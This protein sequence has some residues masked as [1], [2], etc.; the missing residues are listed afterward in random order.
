MSAAQQFDLFSANP[1]PAELRSRGAVS[2]PAIDP[3]ALS[4]D[5]LVLALAGAP[6]R[7]CVG[8]VAEVGRRRL[9]GAISALDALCRRFAG[10]GVNRV[11]PEQAAALDALAAIGGPKAREALARLIA[12]GVVQGPGLRTALAA[13]ARVNVKIPATT[14]LRLLRNDDPQIR[15]AA[16]RCARS[17]PE[18]VSLLRD[19]LDDLHDEVRTAAACALG[20]IGQSEVRPLLAGLLRQA[21]S[22]ELI[23]AIAGVADEE[24]ITLLG[25]IALFTPHL[26][27]AALDALDAIDQPRAEK[28]ATG[29]R[30]RL[31]LE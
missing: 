5:K 13:A 25:R 22:V 30:E 2:R 19:L 31:A 21:P 12:N 16:C 24:T 20:R 23:D 11:V 7:D 1:N 6:M 18:A 15:A 3:A 27:A 8:L 9:I 14:V 26:A 4:D 28:L 29:I 10:F 17:S